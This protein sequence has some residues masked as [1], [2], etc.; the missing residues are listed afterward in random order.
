VHAPN[1][2]GVAERANGQN[3][4]LSAF[5]GDAAFANPEVYELLEW[6]VIWG[7]SV[8]D[9]ITCRVTKLGRVR[10]MMTLNQWKNTR[11]VDHV[12]LGPFNP[13]VQAMAPGVPHLDAFDADVGNYI[14]ANNNF[15]RVTLLGRIM[16]RA[17]GN[18]LNVPAVPQQYQAAVLAL[19]NVTQADLNLI[20][21]PMYQMQRTVD[22]TA[23]VAGHALVPRNIALNIFYLAPVGAAPAVG[24]IDAI[25]NG[26]I[27]AANAA[28]GY[29]QAGTTFARANAAATVATQT[30]ANESILLPAIGA[31][32]VHLQGRF[33]D[34][35]IGGPRLITYC[36][37]SGGA[38][39]SIDVVYLDHFDQ[40]DVQGRTFRAG[41]DYGGTVAARPIVTV[42]LNPPAAGA[43]TY[44]TTLAHELGHALTG[45][46]DH[47][48][49]A[50]NL[51]AGGAIRNG[52]DN[53]SEGQRLWFR[54]NPYT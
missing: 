20:C 25:I 49:D 29:L 1:N 13:R 39:N 48:A 6:N 10:A 45:D 36:N 30:A 28:A 18:Y 34:G 33:A 32:P 31:V 37:A 35:G 9:E 42:T 21:Q 51:M 43:A 53:L 40:A 47:S 46:P 17:R 12:A 54:N 15:D 38:A 11:R 3:L 23:L 14:F 19:Y 2:P 26:H 4:T 44:A 50:T 52:I 24:P 27:A 41:A 7:M 8:D 16:V 5:R 22:L